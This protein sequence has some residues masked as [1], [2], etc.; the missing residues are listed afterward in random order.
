[1]LAT[2]QALRLECLRL[3]DA[4]ALTTDQLIAHAA[5]LEEFILNG[6]PKEE[7]WNFDGSTHHD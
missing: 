5:K 1:M 2:D 4:G 7:E 3:F 6:A